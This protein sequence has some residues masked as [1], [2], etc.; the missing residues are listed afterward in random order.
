MSE[1]GET[2]GEGENIVFSV[3]SSRLTQPFFYAGAFLVFLFFLL[4]RVWFSLVVMATILA[5]AELQ[6]R[7][8][9]YYFTNQRIVAETGILSKNWI[10]V[11]Y[12]KITDISV[13][14]GIIDRMLDIGS[15]KIDT[16]GTGTFEE[17]IDSVRDPESIGRFIQS[18]IADN[19]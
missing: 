3:N 7:S 19:R 11:P 15:I 14:K 5:M 13:N 17:S 1:I 2:L 6:V 8:K 4:T 9:T 18:R 12:A 10:H 16:G